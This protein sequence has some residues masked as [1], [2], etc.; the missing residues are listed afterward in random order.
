MT[1][2]LAKILHRVY[3][4]TGGRALLVL[5]FLLCTLCA[6]IAHAQNP[7]SADSTEWRPYQVGF[8]AAAFVS[9]LEGPNAP[10]NYQF[11][12]RYRLT[13]QWTL[14]TAVRY[15]HQFSDNQSLDLTARTGLDYV[16]RDDGRLQLYV[17]LDAVGGYDRAFNDDKTYRVGAAPVF[18][19]LVFAT[20]YLSFS[21]EPRLV[22]L[23]SYFDNPGN[24]PNADEWAV[25]LKGDSLLIISIH[26]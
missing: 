17:G 15:E 21:V 9:I 22:A 7:S 10:E 13:R 5:P 14:R 18:G 2:L 11:Y 20:D 1:D 8:S 25:E 23:Y 16:V 3:R 4:L 19:M 24:S 6:G 26:F 12:G